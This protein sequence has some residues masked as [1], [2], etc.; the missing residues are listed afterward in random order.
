VFR[1]GEMRVLAAEVVFWRG[2][3]DRPGG[4]VKP[5]L[6][7]GGAVRPAWLGGQTAPP[8]IFGWHGFRGGESSD[9]SSA[10][11]GGEFAGGKFA[12][13]SPPFAQYCWAYSPGTHRRKDE[14]R[15]LLEVPFNPIR[16]HS[17]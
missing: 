4:A 9:F 3:I 17:V 15:L 13:R 10:G 5:A 7:R 6:P 16:T 8:K 11:H 12:R 14:D 1:H 2:R